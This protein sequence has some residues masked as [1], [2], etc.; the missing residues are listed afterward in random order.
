MRACGCAGVRA[1]V[2]ACVKKIECG[3]MRKDNERRGQWEPGANGEKQTHC[4]DLKR[5]C[6]EGN[7]GMGGIN[8][9]GR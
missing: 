5:G 8:D 2:R 4:I 7:K 6:R 3:A 1:C 9:V